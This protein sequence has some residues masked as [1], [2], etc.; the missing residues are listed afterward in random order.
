MRVCLTTRVRRTA[1]SILSYYLLLH[2]WISSVTKE[3]YPV[4]SAQS[5]EDIVTPNVYW[6]KRLHQCHPTALATRAIVEESYR[7]STIAMF[8]RLAVTISS[9]V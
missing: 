9:A 8:R 1:S 4:A 6:I 2:K 7:R 5:L 3:T